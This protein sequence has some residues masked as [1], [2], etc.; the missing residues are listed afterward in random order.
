MDRCHN[1][2]PSMNLRKMWKHLRGRH[3]KRDRPPKMDSDSVVREKLLREAAS[4]P[5]L[6]RK[7][8]RLA[9]TG[10]VMLDDTDAAEPIKGPPASVRAKI[11]E[12]RECS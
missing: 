8:V 1:M 6:Q 7:H 11:E 9:S 2:I 4:V 5:Y 10:F 12:C 3:L